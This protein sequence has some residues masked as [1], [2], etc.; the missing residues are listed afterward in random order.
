[1][2]ERSPSFHSRSDSVDSTNLLEQMENDPE[3]KELYD[4]PVEEISI[5]TVN[6]TVNQINQHDQRIDIWLKARGARK[7]ITAVEGFDMYKEEFKDKKALKNLLK[8]FKVR[9][10]SATV[11]KKNRLK[12]L[13]IT[14]NNPDSTI[15][16]F[17]GDHVDEV[18]EYLMTVHRIREKEIHTH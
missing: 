18:K 10:C 1:M 9:G 15:V 13:K 3:V 7:K 14:F 5:P 8:Y 12:K 16:T 11:Q 6:M 4:S 17:Q 2:A